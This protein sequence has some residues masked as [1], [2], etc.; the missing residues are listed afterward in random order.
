MAI[1]MSGCEWIVVGAGWLAF[2]IAI[3]AIPGCTYFGRIKEKR[4][5]EQ[6][7]VEKINLRP[8]VG[9][10][11]DDR[12]ELQLGPGDG[13]VILAYLRTVG[14]DQWNPMV[15]GYEYRDRSYEYELILTGGTDPLPSG[16]NVVLRILRFVDMKYSSVVRMSGVEV[17]DLYRLVETNYNERL[18]LARSVSV[19]K[20]LRWCENNTVRS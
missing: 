4:M 12:M 15:I 8:R 14:T 5:D 18:N 17:A 20:L 2:Y 19:G 11:V 13:A 16:G 10:D 6:N 3:V 9:K 1:D 7:V